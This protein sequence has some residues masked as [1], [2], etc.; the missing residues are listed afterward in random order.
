MQG[1]HRVGHRYPPVTTQRQRHQIA[2]VSPS[3][4][5]RTVNPDRPPRTPAATPAPAV[6][7]RSPDHRSPGSPERSA[8]RKS[9]PQTDQIAEGHAPGVTTRPARPACAVPAAAALSRRAYTSCGNRVVMPVRLAWGLCPH[10]YC[11]LDGAS[12]WFRSISGVPASITGPDGR[13]VNAG[14]R[15][16]RQRGD[17]DHPGRP[18]RLV[19]CLD[20]DWPAWRVDLIPSYKAHRVAEVDEMAEADVGG[21]RRSEP[22]VEMILEILD[23]YGIATAGAQGYEGRRRAGHA[24]FC[25]A[26]RSRRRRQRRPR[27]LQLVTEDPSRCGCSISAAGCRC[28]D[29]RPGGSGRALRGP[30]WPG[31]AGL[32]RTGVAARRSL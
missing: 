25:R 22:Q 12:M 18:S 5:S 26:A 32:R 21:A 14:A 1:G 24:G 8:A 11:S 6:G 15:V 28:H 10:L 27:P 4:Q 19:V 29:V 13:P 17:P 30:H 31:P 16:S 23:A 3:T 20:L 2:G 7:R 9:C